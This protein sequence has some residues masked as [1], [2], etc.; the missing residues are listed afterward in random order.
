MKAA[1]TIVSISVDPEND[2]PDV[3]RAY[4][5]SFEA[6]PERW[7]FLTGEEDATYALMRES[8]APSVEKLADDDPTIS[9]PWKY[10]SK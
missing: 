6:D 7:W 1:S 2:T 10:L 8:F 3:L 4:A 5:E 9:P